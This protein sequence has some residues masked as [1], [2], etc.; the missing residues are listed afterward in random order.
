MDTDEIITLTMSL[1]L[2]KLELIDGDIVNIV[3]RITETDV[4]ENVQGTYDVEPNVVCEV[5]K[6]DTIITNTGDLSYIRGLHEPSVH[7][8]EFTLQDDSVDDDSVWILYEVAN[9][10]YTT[11]TGIGWNDGD[12]IDI[13]DYIYWERW[14]NLYPGIYVFELWVYDGITY[15]RI[16]DP[17]HAVIS[18]ITLIVEPNVYP[19]ISHPS[20]IIYHQGNVDNY[21]NWIIWDE[22]VSSTYYNV[23]GAYTFQQGSWESGIPIMA[24]IDGYPLG[25]HS[26]QMYA[27]DGLGGF[28]Y[29]YVNVH[30]VTA[31]DPPSIEPLD[32]LIYNKGTTDNYLN[33]YVTDPNVGTTAYEVYKDG[34]LYQSG[35]WVSNSYIEVNVDGLD[36]GTYV[37]EI[38]VD[39]GLGSGNLVSMDVVDVTVVESNNPVIN[40]QHIGDKTDASPG[41]VVVSIADESDLTIDQSGSYNILFNYAFPTGTIDTD[42]AGNKFVYIDLDE[43]IYLREEGTDLKGIQFPI[44]ADLSFTGTDIY[45][46]THTETITVNIDDDDVTGP[47]I[48]VNYQSTV[49]LSYIHPLQGIANIYDLESGVNTFLSFGVGYAYVDN[50]DGNPV[51]EIPEEFKYMTYPDL[52]E[53]ANTNPE[54][55]IVTRNL[56]EGTYLQGNQ[57]EF[58][59]STIE[60]GIGNFKIYHSRN[61]DEDLGIDFDYSETEWLSITR[62]DAEPIIVDVTIPEVI[63]DAE[64][65]TIEVEAVDD[66][67]IVSIIA[68][69]DGT[70]EYDGTFN[71]QTELWEIH[72]QNP[73][74]LEWHDAVIYVT[75]SGG[76]IS[77]DVKSFE[78]IDDDDTGPIINVTYVGQYTDEQPGYIVVEVTDDSG[79]DPMYDPSG[80]YYVDNALGDHTFQLIARDFDNDRD[81]DWAETVIDYIIHISDDDPHKPVILT[82]YIGGYTDGDPGQ[83]VV[84]VNDYSEL[85][86]DPSGTY[87]VD[88]NLGVK[89]YYFT[90]VDNDNDRTDEYG[91]NI[92]SLDETIE[93]LITIIDDDTDGPTIEAYYQLEIYNNYDELSVD[94]QVTDPSGVSGVEV[95]YDSV[96]YY[97]TEIGPDYYN[98]ILPLT[99]ILGE[100]TFNVI[101]TDNDDDRP[102][103]DDTTT[104]EQEFGFYMRDEI[105]Y[106]MQLI[107]ENLVYDYLAEPP[108]ATFDLVLSPELN[109]RGQRDTTLTLGTQTL[110]GTGV[111]IIIGEVS[112]EIGDKVVL[113]T[114]IRIS[115]VYADIVVEKIL[116]LKE[117]V[118]QSSDE[119][120]NKKNR[121]DTML[122]KIDELLYIAESSLYMEAYDKLL[123]DIK[124]K[125]TSEK[126]DENGLIFGNGIF[127][128]PWVICTDLQSE[129][130]SLCD[131]ILYAL[132]N[133]DEPALGTIE[134]V[135]NEIIYDGDSLYDRAVGFSVYDPNGLFA[136]HPQYSY[137][138]VWYDFDPDDPIIELNGAIEYNWVGALSGSN[139]GEYAL[140]VEI[141]DSNY[142]VI[143]TNQHQMTYIDDDDSIDI[144]SFFGPSTYYTQNPSPIPEENLF[145]F[146]VYDG[147]GISEVV[148]LVS[149]DNGLTWT[150]ILS[151]YPMTN[152]YHWE[153]NLTESY[154]IGQLPLGTI[155]LNV[156]VTDNDE[157]W[158]DYSYTDKKTEEFYFELSV[159]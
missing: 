28:G 132:M 93:V 155:L 43:F 31:N 6:P 41:I 121:K 82:Q 148:I 113:G 75:D 108:L 112:N 119:C 77:S 125:L 29:D 157:D 86:E 117:T 33:W 149:L 70:S 55:H 141:L 11:A 87:Y 39:D 139:F 16:G 54:Y 80:T 137:Q 147:S 18:R 97:A 2:S 90:A 144:F 95:L 105:I 76:Q 92:D 34:I 60:I 20:D 84:S 102:P 23:Q 44:V 14:N 22:S 56:Q 10:K 61:A 126:K 120:W 69:I 143:E 107:A 106:Q 127:K 150:E 114:L 68:V 140:K 123:H 42:S 8:M 53:F 98:V 5:I 62:Y 133:V 85:S 145:G 83:I 9:V 32:D 131:E 122:N 79:V 101:A 104:S 13:Q 17:D 47:T 19:A 64:S 130:G 25:S 57:W 142:N 51:S 88:N 38:V 110:S 156:K 71:T 78:V 66:D 154:N 89:I 24:N 26:I 50:G 35:S 46:N 118:D 3:V 159:I 146:D 152:T 4:W 15:E 58:K 12:V 7:I 63:T 48:I 73:F 153:V 94:L 30:V 129:F 91:N 103:S 135:G 72:A 74:V 116:E 134:F 100:Q 27:E 151:N 109:Y 37:F 158:L 67:G 65:L 45:G 1:D 136:I 36:F 40:I 138:G 115:P 52:V 81:D 49:D 99:Y 21:I 124:P 128:N 96:T 59:D 111:H